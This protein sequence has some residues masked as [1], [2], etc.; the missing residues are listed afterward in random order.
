MIKKN[1]K[2]FF[3]VNISDK[4]SSANSNCLFSESISSWYKES[5]ALN[6]GASRHIMVETVSFV[7]HKVYTS[8][9]LYLVTVYIK[10]RSK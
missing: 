7:T 4:L 2:L 5:V 6:R 10:E 8:L 1:E 9:S 3:K